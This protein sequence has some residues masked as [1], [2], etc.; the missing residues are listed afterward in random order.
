MRQLRN[1]VCYAVACA[2]D[3]CQEDVGSDFKILGFL[4]P[5]LGDARKEL[6][7]R[8]KTHDES[9]FLVRETLEPLHQIPQQKPKRRKAA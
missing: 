2:C 5:L 6:R 1:E 9:V 3:D 8:R 4:H 7:E